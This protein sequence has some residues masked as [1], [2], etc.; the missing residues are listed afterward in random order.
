VK[1]I[2]AILIAIATFSQQLWAECFDGSS[3][4]NQHVNVTELCFGENGNI[5]VTVYY[6]NNLSLEPPTSCHAQSSFSGSL[7]EDSVQIAP[8]VGKCKNGNSF[9]SPTMACSTISADI[10]RCSITE[11]SVSF[12][13][14]K[15]R[16][17]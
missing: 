2:S 10:Y 12:I 3:G 11:L 8:M 7:N 5:S 17:I 13:V 1:K 4:F 16:S 14:S 9:N 6:F 15:A